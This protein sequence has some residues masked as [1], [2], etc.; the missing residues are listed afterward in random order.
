MSFARSTLFGMIALLSA[1]IIAEGVVS[2]SAGPLKSAEAH[3]IMT[4][5]TGYGKSSVSQADAVQ[6]AISS[7]VGKG[8][9]PAC[10]R[11]GARP[12]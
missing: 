8:G 1:S 10:C 11:K 12:L 3:C 2:A 5:V 4:G 9:V 7:C 6:K